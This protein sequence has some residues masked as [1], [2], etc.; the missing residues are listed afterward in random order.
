MLQVKSCT[1]ISRNPLRDKSSLKDNQKLNAIA[2]QVEQQSAHKISITFWN[3]PS[4]Q[5]SVR[6]RT[7]PIQISINE[8]YNSTPQKFRIV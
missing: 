5:F 2:H 4:R 6:D 7:I 8:A 1:K 3:P